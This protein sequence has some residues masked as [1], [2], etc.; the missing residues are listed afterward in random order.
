MKIRQTVLPV[1]LLVLPLIVAGCDNGSTAT[2]E[3]TAQ[4]QLEQVEVALGVEQVVIFQR[5]DDEVGLQNDVNTWLSQ[6]H[7][8]AAVSRVLQSQSGRITRR[9]TISI[10]YKK[11]R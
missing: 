7:N 6:N 8:K 5:T 4:Q 9:T 1:A 3:A 10:F 2:A 11:I